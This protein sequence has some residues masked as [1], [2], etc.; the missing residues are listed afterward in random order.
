VAAATTVWAQQ[1]SP[2]AAEAE[3]ALR[4]RVE[5][6]FQLQVDRKFRQAESLVAE[7][8]KDAYYD[9][10]K[11]DIK[12]FTIQEVEMTDQ[13]TRARVTIKGRV[14]VTIPAAGSIDMEAPATTFWKFENGQW[15]YFI[16]QEA[17]I[18]TPFGKIKNTPA[19][20]ATPPPSPRALLQKGLGA[21]ALDQQVTIDRRSVSL[22]SDDP[23]QTVT[24][25]N[26]LPGGIDLEVGA[27]QS[28]AFTVE[29]R[30][31]HLEAGEKTTV[32]FSA[33]GA[34][35]ETKVVPILVSPLSLRLEIQVATK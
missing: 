18:D 35:A 9:G 7:D 33:T 3:A 25:T 30:K 6:F 20:G 17:G 27:P 12:S 21:A 14:I 11:F 8:S 34:K 16:D 29:I 4:A 15:V 5:Q 23:R 19:D 22:T 24:V 28:D 32:E 1:P 26:G 13:N 10:R 2:A 31:K